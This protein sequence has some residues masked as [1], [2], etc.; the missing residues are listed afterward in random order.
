MYRHILTRKES[1][2]IQ[3]VASQPGLAPL[4]IATVTKLPPSEITV[5]VDGL[6]RRGIVETAADP[7]KIKLTES[8]SAM[9]QQFSQKES[10]APR[11]LSSVLITDD[12][13]GERMQKNLESPQLDTD[14][15]NYINN[16]K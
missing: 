9:L 5:I 16:L 15:E 8:G 6:R 13:F 14:L 11:S 7:S 12:A 1:D 3:A 4:E 10:N 2:L